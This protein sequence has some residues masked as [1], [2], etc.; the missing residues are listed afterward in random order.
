[1]EKIK[2]ILKITEYEREKILEIFIPIDFTKK[3]LI[4]PETVDFLAPYILKVLAN[5]EQT[6]FIQQLVYP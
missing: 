3:L 2:K 1:M 4:S 6:L 5:V